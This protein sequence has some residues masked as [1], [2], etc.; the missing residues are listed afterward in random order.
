MSLHVSDQSENLVLI[1]YWAGAPSSSVS[2][3]NRIQTFL[4]QLLCDIYLFSCK[5]AISQVISDWLYP[6][7]FH[8]CLQY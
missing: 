4:R 8:F 7:I 5:C 3:F 6:L 2:N 1:P